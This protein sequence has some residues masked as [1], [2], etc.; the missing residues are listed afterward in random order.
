MTS[1]TGSRRSGR[2]WNQNAI[3]LLMHFGLL[4]GEQM[5]ALIE[6]KQARA[7]RCIQM[8]ARMDLLADT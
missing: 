1:G 5:A 4:L 2:R 6:T 7:A 8:A 3:N